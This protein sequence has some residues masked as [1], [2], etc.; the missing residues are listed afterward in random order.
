MTRTGEQPLDRLLY[1]IT[2]GLL[3]LL[4]RFPYPWRQVCAGVI[5]RLLFMVNRKHRRIAHGNMK[6]AFGDEL[7]AEQID[8]VVGRVFENLFHILFEFGWSQSLNDQKIDAHFTIHGYD[9]YQAAAA[10]GK[11]I[12][13]LTAH[14]GN[15]E[16]LPIIGHMHNVPFRVVYRPLDTP[17]LDRIFKES[18]SRYGGVPIPTRRGAMRQIYKTLRK[19]YPVAMLMDQNV[20]WYEG[21]FVDFFNHR[22]CTNTGMALLALKSGA[23]VVPLFLIR[24]KERFHAVVGP[25]LETIRSGDLTKD[26]ERNTQLYNRVIEIFVKRFPDQWF[27]VHQRWKTRPDC[28]VAEVLRP[29]TS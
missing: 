27:W 25:E 8:A 3:H 21:A 19:G 26:V 6:R 12:L 4:G 17:F 11:G 22:A 20:D 2:C 16:L 24:A 9:D 14:F 10:K 29:C 5:G 15:W 1:T 23:P 18:R 7:S 28:P 13:L